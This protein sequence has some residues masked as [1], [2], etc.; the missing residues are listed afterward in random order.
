MSQPTEQ[1]WMPHQP[2][3]PLEPF[4]KW[5]LDFVG[6]LKLAGA[7]IGNMYIIVATE[8]LYKYI[9]CRFGWSTEL[10][11]D[12]GGDFIAQ[13]VESLTTFYA[14]VHKKSTSYYPQAN[15]LVESTNKTLQ[16]LLKKIVKENRTDWATKLHSTLWH[17][18]KLTKLASGRHPSD[19]HLD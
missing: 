5:G 7:R 13:V 17:T 19:S 10:I 1:A 18:R 6:P 12:Q 3:L 16:N 4:K 8:F 14:V 15:G 11:R 2:V 9:W